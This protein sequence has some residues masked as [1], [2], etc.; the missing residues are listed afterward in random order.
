MTTTSLVI[1]ILSCGVWHVVATLLI[2]EYLRVRE[3]PVH[4]LLLRWKVFAYLEQ[5]RRISRSEEGRVG[6]LFYHF[7]VPMQIAAVAALWLV[8]QGVGGVPAS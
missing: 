1:L 7:V 4:F 2:Y 6:S 5:Y 8:V 3:V